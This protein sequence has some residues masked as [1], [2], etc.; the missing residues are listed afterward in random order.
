MPYS[1]VISKAIQKQ[2]NQLPASIKLKVQEKIL[3][4]QS[5]PRPAGVVKLKGYDYQYR[6]RVGDY[7]IRYEIFDEAAMVQILQCK[8]RSEVYRDK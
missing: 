3:L 2:I 7:R 6:L 8:H 5:D 4:L 1:V